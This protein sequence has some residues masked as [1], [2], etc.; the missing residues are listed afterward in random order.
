M[1][2]IARARLEALAGALEE[3]SRR[4]RLTAA[5][6][7]P[8]LRGASLAIADERD[9]VAKQI[10]QAI[11]EDDGYGFEDDDPTKPG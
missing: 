5:A 2:P 10:R 3:S 8:A 6:A 1:K 9:E 11:A 7:D 4:S